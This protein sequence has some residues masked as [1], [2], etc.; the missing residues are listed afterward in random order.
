VAF[1]REPLGERPPYQLLV[2]N[3]QNPGGHKTII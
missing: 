2:V 1:L 3:N